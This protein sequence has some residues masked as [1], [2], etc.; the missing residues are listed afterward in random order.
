M[1]IKAFN[2]VSQFNRDK[3]SMDQIP[4]L[5]I[6]FKILLYGENKI[7]VKS[8]CK[9]VFGGRVMRPNKSVL[10]LALLVMAFVA[11]GGASADGR[12]RGGHFRSHVVIGGFWGPS[13]YYPPYYAPYY[14][15]YYPPA[16]SV[17]S[18]PPAYIEKDESAEPSTPSG[19]WY[20]CP[21]K[22]AYYPYVR[23]C[24]GRWQAV[25]AEPPSE[26]EK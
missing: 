24:P 21:E 23:E 26:E 25:P 3:R 7:V 16:V 2:N 22:K 13:W 19:I 20:Y 6:F 12:H 18:T 14:P 17:P 4:V 8:W 1:N 10:V 11:I 15:Y 9:W 5:H